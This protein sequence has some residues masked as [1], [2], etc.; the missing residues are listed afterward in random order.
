MI[1]ALLRAPALVLLLSACQ[2]GQVPPVTGGP[3]SNCAHSWDG[4]HLPH[5]ALDSV[6]LNNSSS[7]FVA[8]LTLW[9]MDGNPITLKHKGPGFPIEI[10]DRGDADSGWLGLA[11]IW[12]RDGH[13]ARARVSINMVLMRKAAARY[14][15]SLTDMVLHVGWQE[16]GHVAGLDHQRGVDDSAM[17]DCVGR[18][19]WPT[20]IS[21]PKAVGFN[22]HD[23]Q[24]LYS[25]Y[26]HVNA[27]S[28]PPACAGSGG[29][30][31]IV[32]TFPLEG[33]QP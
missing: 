11:E 30:A 23:I 19:D 7:A 8:D 33:A 26:R 1:N 16:I 32:H 21:N 22:G 14:D 17:E 28:L 27:D 18:S 5:D 25:I 12:K 9:N 20:C 2:F 10:V 24:E 6:V 15:I 4:N 3:D 29:A 31:I 13:I